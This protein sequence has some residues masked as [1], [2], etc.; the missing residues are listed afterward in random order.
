M[1]MGNG[2]LGI[3]AGGLVL[4]GDPGLIHQGGDVR[5]E[6]TQAIA[7]EPEIM[8][9]RGNQIR[10]NGRTIRG[11]WLVWQTAGQTRIGVES[12][13]LE[14]S[15]GVRLLDATQSEFQGMD[16]FGMG[17]RLPV[18]F[19]NPYR[20]LDITDLATAANWRWQ[21]QGTVLELSTP[22]ATILGL[23]AGNQ[24]WGKRVVID[25]DRPVLWRQATP[26]TIELQGRFPEGAIPQQAKG[27][28]FSLGQLLGLKQGD[29]EALP[30]KVTAQNNLTTLTFPQAIASQIQVSTLTNPPRLVIDLR[31]DAKP[32]RT[33]QWLPGVLW[34]Q[35]NIVL[36]GKNNGG[37]G[38]TWLEIDPTKNKLKF[39]P[40][41]PSKQT[42]IGLATVLA[43]VSAN[44]AIAGINAGFFNRNNYYALGAV[45]SN[46]VWRSSPILNR[47]VVA[48]DNAGNWAFNRLSYREDIR[49]SN[50]ETLT[51]DL[52]NSGYVKAGVAR[53]S[54]AWGDSY[55]PITDYEVIV[56]VQSRASSVPPKEE[57]I[58]QEFAQKGGQG[59]YS[60]PRD[61]YLLVFRSFKSGAAKIPVGTTL[62]RNQL[63][64]PTNIGQFPNVMGAGPLL[65]QNGQIVLNGGA[66]Q[67]SAAF[68]SQSA[69]RSAIARTGDGKIIL[70]TVHGTAAESSGATLR[71]WSEIMLRLGAT[72]ALNLDGGGSSSLAIGGDL[73]D[74]HAGSVGRVNN[75]IGLF[76]ES[77]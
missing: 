62:E 25:L 28:K 1:V 71:E 76:L 23:R 21:A 4:L 75:S 17:D 37:F 67:F 61:G 19:Q 58:K 52:L 6:R 47:G 10:L 48:W 41:S 66:E 32:N 26:T 2:W 22:T 42:I 15:L 20:Y 35:Q 12:M 14:K 7:S 53:Y 36:P 38:V 49:G 72:D 16:W 54:P 24:A 55:K 50:G 74:R 33:I 64:N 39:A 27:Q 70:A 44:G 40:I 13:G 45:R 57:V 51:S 9:V 8:E 59:S 29:A 60:I 69:S 56:T 63:L 77:P 68:N 73:G 30:F 3:V 43:Q 5:L 34:R 11:N 46:G 31:K 65:V 18:N